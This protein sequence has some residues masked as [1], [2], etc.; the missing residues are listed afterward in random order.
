MVFQT[1]SRK[2]GDNASSDEELVSEHQIK[3]LGH[4]EPPVEKEL[5]EQ[6]LV[7]E[8]NGSYASLVTTLEVKYIWCT[9]FELLIYFM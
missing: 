2:Q 6:E 9:R 8:E 7:E 1:R 4:Q 3:E 5:F